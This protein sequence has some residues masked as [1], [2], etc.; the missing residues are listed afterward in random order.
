MAAD[1]LDRLL[2]ALA[3]RL[4]AYSVCEVQQG[5]RLASPAFEATTLHFVLQGSGALR[6]GQG[7]WLP[8]A[9]RTV[10]VVPPRQSFDVG[11]PAFNARVA[12][13]DTRCSLLADGLVRFTAGDGSQDTLMLCGAISASY[14]SALGLFDLL[15]QP[16]IEDFS[17]SP[18]LRQVFDLMLA[19]VRD[20]GIGTQAMA[21]VLMK[22]CLIALLRQHLGRDGAE[23]ALFTVLRHPKLALAVL[24][25]IEQPAAMHS[26][27]S[28][29]GLAGMSRSSFAAHFSQAFQQGPID[30]VQKV[31]LR[32]GARLLMTTD[33]SLKVIAQSVG[34]AGPVPFARAFRVTYGADPILYRRRD[35]HDEREPIS[36]LKKSAF[37]REGLIRD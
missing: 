34:Y 37:R 36:A 1:T 17:A 8:F 31:R 35:G 12:R 27:E 20:P 33:L 32:V 29:A 4:H 3:V 6:V 13:L 25:V 19:E 10:L 9:A 18:I 24:A 21:E 30:F 26:V 15:L 5:W 7:P 2:N 28:L 23:S 11:E 14:S 22:H 16:M